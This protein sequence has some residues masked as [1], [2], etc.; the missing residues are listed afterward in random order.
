MD[1]KCSCLKGIIYKYK[2]MFYITSN[3]SQKIININKCITSSK[4]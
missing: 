3:L 4:P 2:K 1:K